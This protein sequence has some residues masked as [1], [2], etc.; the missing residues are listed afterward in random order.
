MEELERYLVDEEARKRRAMLDGLAQ[1]EEGRLNRSL[2]AQIANTTA[3]TESLTDQRD[4]NRALNAQ[5]LRDKVSARYLPGDVVDEADAGLVGGEAQTTLPGR[6]VPMTVG[7]PGQRGAPVVP[8]VMLP[9]EPTGRTIARGTPEQRQQM[10]QR[11]VFQQMSDDPSTRED[12]KLWA[13]GAIGGASVPSELLKPE[14]REV[15]VRADSA[16]RTVERLDDATGQWVPFRGLAPGEKAHWL[17]E[18]TPPTSISLSQF[19]PASIDVY[20]RL[21]EGGTAATTVNRGNAPLMN[22]ALAR[23]AQNGP[24]AVENLVG[25]RAGYTADQSA[26][27]QTSR[28]LSAIRSYE[29]MAKGNIQMLKDTIENLTD[30]G[31][32]LLNRPLRSLQQMTGNAEVAKF[33]TALRPVQTEVARILNGSSQLAGVVSVHAQTEVEEM[34]RGD[35]TVGQ[36]MAA[37]DVLTQDM[38]RRAAELIEEQKRLQ[39]SIRSRGSQGAPSESGE[40]TDTDPAG[41]L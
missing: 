4:A 13:R 8:G 5:M 21:L 33:F 18:P 41:I 10:Q 15:T 6:S 23:I 38:T 7:A 11:A 34:L 36:M 35:Y 31:I 17:Q 9:T 19:D 25:A 29:N 1:T 27:T 30:T 39:Q 26:L 12:V 22:A 2:D 32:P 37:L 28:N 16:R 20:A 24:T 3:N 14:V 40:I